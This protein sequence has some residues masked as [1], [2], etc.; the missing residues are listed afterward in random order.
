MA[1]I[2][3][4]EAAAR[5]AEAFGV[6]RR[7][8]PGVPG[9]LEREGTVGR[10]GLAVARVARR[11]HAVEHVHTARDRL[12]EILGLADAHEI[13]WLRRRQETHHERR[14]IVHH[15][16]RLPTAMPPIA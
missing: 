8:V 1:E 14:Q 9:L 12:D 7:A 16:L 5:V 4:R 2:G 13:A 10:E 11:Q 15:R 6:E 3:A